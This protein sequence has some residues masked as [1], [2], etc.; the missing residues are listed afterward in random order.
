MA[1]M[2]LLT[3]KSAHMSP[4]AERVYLNRVTLFFGHAVGNMVMALIGA[5]LLVIV[6]YNAQ[7]P[8][9]R[10]SIWFAAVFLA[11]S[12]VAIIEH[13]F[14][15]IDLT[16]DNAPVWVTRRILSG[17]MVAMT[18]GIAPFM[19][20]GHDTVVSE[21]FIF[22]ILSTMVAVGV[23]G[24]S[25][26][27]Q[28]SLL[29]NIMTLFPP[30]IFFFSKGDQVH[31]VLGVTSIIWQ[32]VVLKKGWAVAKSSI[33]AIELNERLRQESEEHR[34]TKEQMEYL[35]YHDPL[36][37]LANRR[38]FVEWVTK[39]LSRAKRAKTGIGFLVI[40]LN[41]FK[42]INDTLGHD[43]GDAVLE[44]VGK[45]IEGSVREGDFVTRMG[46][47]EFCIVAENVG[48]RKDLD[49]LAK[50]LMDGLG[51]TVT[52]LGQELTISAGIGLSLFPEDGEDLR[53]VMKTADEA[54]YEDKKDRKSQFA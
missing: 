22:I 39:S 5:G 16:Y 29:L 31:L 19:L 2:R 13:R 25:V 10:L 21:M 42:E 54:M 28:Y 12:V 45:R 26:M 41:D 46:G 27:P 8:I 30:T 40:D 34:Q 53:M 43:V 51:G 52:L 48:D 44:Y 4:L 37:G 15:S 32:Y 18:Y 33:K 17:S 24:Y 49:V 14:R 7:V 20:I 1:L 50:K 47:D 35:A 38:Y 6:L 23:T 3:G 9:E 11:S 36:T